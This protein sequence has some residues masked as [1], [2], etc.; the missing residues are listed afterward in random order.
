MKIL[1]IHPPVRLNDVPKHIP[2]GLGILM[3]VA[4]NLGHQVAFL[5]LNAL[6]ISGEAVKEAICEDRFDVVGI[7]GLSS[8][9][10]FI[11]P[12]LKLIKQFQPQ[13][14]VMAGGGFLTSMP[15]EAMQLCPEIDVGVVGEGEAT[16]PD[17]LD[18][19]EDRRWDQVAGVIHRLEGKPMRTA[20]R[21]LIADMDDIPYPHYDLIPLDVYFENSALMFSPESAA[22][23]RRIDILM[24]RGCPRMCTFCEHGGMS[25]YDLERVYEGGNFGEEPIYRFNSPRYTVELVKYLRFRFG[26]DFVSILDENMT[27]YRKRVFELC[28]E[29]ERAGLAGL[30]KFGC[31]GDVG[32]VTLDMLKRLREVGCSY[33]S[34][35]GESAS[36]MILKA[37]K[38]NTTV[39]QMQRALDWTVQSGIRGVMTFMMGYPDETTQT[40]YETME[41]WRRNKM[42]VKPF[43]ITPYPGTELYVRYKRQILKE[44]GGSLDRFLLSLDDATDISVNM[45][46]H[47]ND[48]ELLGLQ[49]LMYT[50]DFDRL[51]R[52]AEQK[53]MP[54]VELGPV[55]TEVAGMR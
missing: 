19:V 36:N 30:V 33:I 42:I 48:V 10:K 11:R 49:Q 23:T 51:R 32:G 8:Q 37:V 54:I 4:E 39:E 31:L 13:A 27:T 5:D 24:E 52:F 50:Q 17:L 38:K 15:E 22:A 6:R 14:V 16:L 43:L 26:V 21:K 25:R 29:W 18:H 34:Y 55:A 35:G 1:F 12:L 9:Y 45:S 28:D 46:K 44:W 47:F 40:I 2:Y 20:P 7:G 41:F 53:G 3:S